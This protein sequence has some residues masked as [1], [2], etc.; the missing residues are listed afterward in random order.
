MLQNVLISSELPQV[1]L[2][3]LHGEC[4][5]SAIHESVQIIVQ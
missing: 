4:K 2:F 3:V 5:T 1:S